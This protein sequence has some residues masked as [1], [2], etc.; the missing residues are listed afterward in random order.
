MRWRTVLAAVGFRRGT[1]EPSEGSLKAA[2]LAAWV[3]AHPPEPLAGRARLVLLHS[4]HPEE[5]G[6]T[7][8]LREGEDA[9]SEE[10]HAALEALAAE[11]EREAG[12][13]ELAIVAGKAWREIA[14]AAL[15]GRADLLVL[16]KRS[17]ARDDGPRVGATAAKVLRSAPGPVWPVR[18]EHDLAHRLVLAASDLS[19]LGDEVCALAAWVAAESGAEL[20]LLHAHAL[21]SDGGGGASAAEDPGALRE[22][23]RRRLLAAARRRRLPVEPETH[24]VRGAPSTAICEAVSHLAPDLLVLGAVSRGA[25]PAHLVGDT[26]ERVLVRA[27]CS[28]LFLKPDDFV[29][30]L[31]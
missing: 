30:P 19:P 9:L 28:L 7:S 22:Q 23:A 1:D 10:R 26:A 24:L 12:S 14:R 21:A 18:P 31:A 13:C 2:R 3:A 11:L 15:E 20:H 25:T 5:R 29:S 8:G 17:E 4:T 6:G 16:G 27:G